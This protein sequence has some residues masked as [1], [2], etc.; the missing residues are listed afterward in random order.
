M[1]NHLPLNV[2]DLEQLSDPPPVLRTEDAELYGQVRTYFLD[3]FTP[4]DIMQ[5][6]LVDR[7][8][9][10]AWL[11]KR[12]SRHQTV[13]VERWHRQSLEFQ[14]QRM[15]LQNTRK[16]DRTSNLADKMRQTPADVAHLQDLED[17]ILESITDV[18]EILERTPTELEHNRA[19][20]KGIIFQEQL[21]KLTSSATKRFNEAL[22]LLEHYNEGL[23][24]RLRQAAQKLLES[25]GG[26]QSENYL[27]QIEA[28]SIGSADQPSSTE[29]DRN[30]DPEVD[31]APASM[32][33]D[34]TPASTELERTPTSTE[35]DE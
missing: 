5:W 34:Q 31:Q 3:C 28:P 6:Y 17:T 19:L 10:S 7:L 24:G 33:V 21:D 4:E 12:Y 25:S 29:I 22:V 13:A 8:V 32:G 26:Q 15:K 16:E 14:A 9:D 27:R 11:I 30:P 18:D 1:T 35:E 20:E 23:G 2:V